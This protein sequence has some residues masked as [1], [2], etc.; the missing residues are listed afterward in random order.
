MGVLRVIGSSSK[1]NG[2]ILRCGSEVLLLELGVQWRVIKRALDYNIRGIVGALVSHSHL[3]HAKYISQVLEAGINVYSN[4]DVV[5]KNKGVTFASTDKNLYLGGF[6]VRP[7]LLKH[8][9]PCGYLIYHEDLGKLVFITDT[10]EV[11]YKFKGVNH[12]LIE[13]NYSDAYMMQKMM[14]STIS[15]DSKVR[16]ADT[17]LSLEKALDVLKENRDEELR[18]IV[19]LHLSDRNSDAKAFYK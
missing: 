13:S 18:T 3:D 6:K 12:Y 11:D 17:H 16:V 10:N 15:I 8:D 14:D 5:E 7:F 2:Y 1:G 9:V 19:L 4:Q